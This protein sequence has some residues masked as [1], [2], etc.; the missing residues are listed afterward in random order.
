ML[1]L[2]LILNYFIIY[3]IIWYIPKDSK[4]FCECEY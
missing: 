4:M 3:L 2:Q 1:Y